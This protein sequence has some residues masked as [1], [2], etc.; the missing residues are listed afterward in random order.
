M[1]SRRSKATD[2]KKKVRNKVLER[3]NSRCVICGDT[4]MLEL[5]HVFVSRSAGG[6]GVEENLATLCKKHHMTLDSGKKQE[7]RNIRLAVESYMRSKYGD[8]DIK[9]LK[10]KKWG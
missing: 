9:S 5:A 3:D 8:I 7:Q 2:I 4:N 6:L 1:K 10:Y